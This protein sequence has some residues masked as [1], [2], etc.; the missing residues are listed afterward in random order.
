MFPPIALWETHLELLLAHLDP[1]TCPYPAPSPPPLQYLVHLHA[2]SELHALD[3]GTTYGLPYDK[4]MPVV[5][6][7]EAAAGSGDR[8]LVV[9]SPTWITIALSTW[10]V[11]FAVLR[12]RDCGAPPLLRPRMVMEVLLR[13]ARAAV[14]SLRYSSGGGGGSDSGSGSG[15]SSSPHSEQGARITP[16]ACVLDGT[17]SPDIALRALEVAQAVMTLH[18]VSSGR[19]RQ[20]TQGAGGIGNDGGGRD[21]SGDGDSGSGEGGSSGAGGSG[22]VEGGGGVSASAGVGTTGGA[23][24]GGS[25]SEGTGGGA[26]WH[27]DCGCMDAGGAVRVATWRSWAARRRFADTWWRLVVAAVHAELDDE[28]RARRDP[29]ANLRTMRNLLGA[30]FVVPVGLEGERGATGGRTLMRSGGEML[31]Q[32][33]VKMH[34]AC[35]VTWLPQVPYEGTLARPDKLLCCEYHSTASATA[36]TFQG[37]SGA[38][39]A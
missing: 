1:S 13:A 14:D 34:M 30:A 2:V 6:C 21:A 37:M 32:A 38:C 25:P 26:E 39:V 36:R 33:V 24:S 16:A 20:G 11:R 8:S 23:G 27:E 35:G 10:R 3:G 31:C 7:R 9:L 28:G 18:P 29:R 22:G 19:S 15:T 4:L 5:A 17:G 12:P